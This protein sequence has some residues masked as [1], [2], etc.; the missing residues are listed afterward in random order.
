MAQSVKRQTLSLVQ[1]FC[2]APVS[3]IPGNWIPC[4]L[5]WVQSFM[6][7]RWL[8]RLSTPHLN[9]SAK[10]VVILTDSRIACM[11]LLSPTDS[12]VSS[13]GLIRGLLITANQRRS[14]KI[15]W[16]KAHAGIEGNEIVG[17]LQKQLHNHPVI[18]VSCLCAL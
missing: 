1:Y 6:L 15:P 18:L 2:P 4:I 10:N 7:F 11:M 3:C 5:F 16:I 8:L 13:V 9:L 12:Y 14:L 17:I